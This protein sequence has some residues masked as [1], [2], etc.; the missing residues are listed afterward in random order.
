MID[1]RNMLRDKGKLE[2]IN[3]VIPLRYYLENT[4]QGL[5]VHLVKVTNMN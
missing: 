1:F 4:H 2:N 5:S 3:I